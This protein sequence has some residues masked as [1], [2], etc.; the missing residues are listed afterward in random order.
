[1]NSLKNLFKHNLIRHS[2][3]K[4][5]VRTLTYYDCIHKTSAIA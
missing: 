1:M 3:S 2:V 4:K 5:D